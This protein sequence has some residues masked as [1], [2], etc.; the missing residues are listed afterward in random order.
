M[1]VSP[2]YW[3][4]GRVTVSPVAGTESST[5]SPLPSLLQTVALAELQETPMSVETITSI[6]MNAFFSC[7]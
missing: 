1:M 5:K 3:L 2:A 6:I 7:C 4:S